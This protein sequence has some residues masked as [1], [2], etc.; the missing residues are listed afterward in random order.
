MVCFWK[1]MKDESAG[2]MVENVIVL[3]VV[4]V[5]IIFMIISAFLVHDRTTIE[6]AAKR[7]AIYASHCI[8][9]PNY[10]SLVGQSGELDFS[11]SVESISFSSVG[12]NIKAYRYITGGASVQGVVETEVKK[13]VS[14]S[15]IS[16]IPQDSITITCSQENKIIYQ[17]IDVKVTSTYHL[18]GWIE[19]F[20]LESE[21]KISTEAKISAV[22]P[23]EF[24]RNADLVVDLIT[25]VDSATGGHI[26]KALDS[27]ASMA[28]KLSE[29]I[30]ME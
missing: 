17:D 12:K 25:Q 27:I 13:I 11:K 1:K 23:D 22:D 26:E 19:W 18:P 10:A 15:R 21:Y 9:D 6:S 7:G 5:V 16:W 4:F 20:G 8:A 2:V 3:P 30:A 24:I 14:K 29:W 28:S